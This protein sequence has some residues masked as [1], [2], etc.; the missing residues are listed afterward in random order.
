M[1]DDLGRRYPN[2]PAVTSAGIT[3]GR[4][5]SLVSSNTTQRETTFR[6]NGAMVSVDQAKVPPAG[7]LE[8]PKDWESR[9]KKR[10]GLNKSILTAKE[11]QIV[12]ALSKPVT[13][14]VHR[15]EPYQHQR[16][17]DRRH[18]DDRD[19]FFQ[20]C[21]FQIVIAVTVTVWLVYVIDHSW[22]RRG[23]ERSVDV[24]RSTVSTSGIVG[25]VG[26]AAWLV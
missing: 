11:Q 1:A 12:T 14:A 23:T 7:D 26:F 20:K 2:N 3:T 5:N 6:F 21:A 22:T 16:T 17:A 15:D 10:V 8:F 19:L 18:D 4:L 25:V 9:I 13:R 24:R